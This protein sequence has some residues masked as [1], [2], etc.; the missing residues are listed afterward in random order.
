MPLFEY[1]GRNIQGQLMKGHLEAHSSERVAVQ[2]IQRGV[3]PV[4]IEAVRVSESYG[5]QIENLLGANR[6]QVNDLIMFCRQMYT[7]TKSGMP[8]VKG[9]RSLS[10]SL[11]HESFQN[12]LENVTYRLESGA[13]LSSALAHHPKVFNHLFISMISVGESTGRLEKAFEQLAHYLERDERNR[14]CLQSALRYP[15]FVTIALIAAIVIV[16]IWV[17]PEF[18]DMFNKFGSALP[19]V[20]RALIGMSELLVVHGAWLALITVSLFFIVSYYINGSAGRYKWHR[21][22]LRLPIVGDIIYRAS[23]AR[24]MRSFSLM[25]QAGVP[26]N[27]ALSL[28]AHAIDNVYLS[29]K[30]DVIRKGIESGESLLKTHT[31]AQ[32]LPPLV[33]QMIAV[34]EESGQVD[35]L[36]AEVAEFYER[37]V[38]Y[39]LKKLSDKVEP[40]LIIFMAI[41]VAMLALGIF[42]PLWDMYSANP[43]N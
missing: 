24:Y 35:N 21:N 31:Q 7:I 25:L 11:R 40:I 30:I 43:H 14:R 37:E 16:N 18:A 17:I 3:T 19:L 34:G 36:L 8:L 42:L 13:T 41:F 12:I 26:L 15:I 1:S 27:R 29:E 2:L 20:T 10:V 23:M 9:I 5:R 4:K 32:L 22:K 6:V 38:D 39:D 28:C 33:I